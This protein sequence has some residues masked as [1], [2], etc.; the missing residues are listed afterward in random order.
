MGD[1]LRVDLP[2]LRAA[3]PRVE[4]VASD[5]A[6]TLTILTAR[7]DR[8]GACWGNDDTGQRFAA[9]YLPAAATLRQ[10]FADLHDGVASI[11]QSLSTVA[12]NVEAVDGRTESRFG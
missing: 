2:G 7:L 4:A 3:Q 8:E 6:T 10:A 11:A 9:A 5:I 1:V 12:S